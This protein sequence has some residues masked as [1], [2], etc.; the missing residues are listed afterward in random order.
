MVERDLAKVDVA[1]PTPV[2]RSKAYNYISSHEDTKKIKNSTTNLTNHH[3]Q[4]KNDID[5]FVIV[6]VVSGKIFSFSLWLSTL[7]WEFT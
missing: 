2:S 7:V 6:R 1:G 4:K 5:F 3:K